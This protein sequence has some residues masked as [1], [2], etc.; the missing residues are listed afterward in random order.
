M[1]RDYIISNISASFDSLQCV[2]TAR[3]KKS[4]VNCLKNSE[5]VEH[6]INSGQSTG[7]A[8]KT[9]NENETTR[10][11]AMGKSVFKTTSG[12]IVCLHLM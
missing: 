11:S 2:C 9:K 10:T 4:A 5:H 7:K 3:A 8:N 1:S 6:E 12:D